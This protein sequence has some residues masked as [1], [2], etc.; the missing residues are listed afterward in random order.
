MG[1]NKQL[2]DNNQQIFA[3]AYKIILNESL[4]K[5][6]LSDTLSHYF[7]SKYGKALPENKKNALINQLTSTWMI[8]FIRLDPAV[9]LEK[10]TCPILAINGNKDLQVPS[11]E[12]LEVIENIFRKSENTKVKIKELEGLNHLFQECETGAPNEYATIEQTISPIALKE[13]MNWINIQVK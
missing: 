8:N 7:L 10:V 4:E 3:G 5:E 6:V 13:I 12:N 2:V 1:V 11:K 9:Y